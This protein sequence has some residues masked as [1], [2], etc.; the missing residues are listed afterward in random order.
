MVTIYRDEAKWIDLGRAMHGRPGGERFRAAL[1]VARHCLVME[2]VEFPLSVG[3]YI[4]TWRAGDPSR[5]RRLAQTM[6]ELSRFSAHN[7]IS[8]A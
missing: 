5:R 2:L 7:A 1:D 8:T 3:H 6:L 4:E